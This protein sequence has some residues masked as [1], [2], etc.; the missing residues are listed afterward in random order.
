M[1]KFANEKYE[2]GEWVHDEDKT[3]RDWD[4]AYVKDGV[5]RW[6]SN[7]NVPFEDMLRGFETLGFEFDMQASIAAR[8]KDTQEFLANYRRNP[9]TYSAEHLAE[10]RAA[11][12]P[13]ETV[14]NVITG[15]KFKL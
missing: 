9:P 14:V 7:D 2:N 15:Q 6:K 1:A 11:F 8:N 13:G 4:R 12:G 5:V 3:R 10:M